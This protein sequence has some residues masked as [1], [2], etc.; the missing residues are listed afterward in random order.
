MPAIRPTLAAALLTA[1]AAGATHAA[2]WSDT[3][4]GFRTGSKFAEPFNVNDIHKDILSFTHVS[5]YKYGGNFLNVDF[6]KS[7]DK[8]P[9][10]AG[11][12]NGAHEIYIVYRHTLDIEKTF[13]MPMKFGPIRGAGLTAGF[14][15]NTKTDA[16]YNSKK[17]MLVVGPT[18]FVDVPGFLNVGLYLL[19][20]SNAPFST[21]SGV[22]TPRYTYDT[23]PMLNLAWGMPL[24]GG[25]PL[26]FSGYMNWIASKGNNE[27]GGGTAPETNIDMQ[28]M[29][30]VGQ[31]AG[32]PK[33][34]FKV[35]LGYQYWRNKFGNRTTAAGAGA[36]PGATAK[37]PMLRAEYHF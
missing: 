23:H 2:D 11:S 24:P 5:G 16:G 8:D 14:D 21:F 7:D 3:S 30:D 36:G 22:S 20:E 1:A 10:G 13:G 19:K 12:T 9:A 28:L 35:G 25:L 17:R 33:N 34:T 4:I 26:S 32:G 15:L 29:L 27:F 37:T 18:L 31:L 6:L